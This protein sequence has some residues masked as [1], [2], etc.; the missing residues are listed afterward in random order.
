MPRTP[1]FSRLAAALL[2]AGAAA[3][4]ARAAEAPDPLELLDSTLAPPTVPYQ[5]H[6]TV[7]QWFGR[8][9]RTEEMRVFVKPPD[10]IRREFLAPDGR[11]TRVS[12]SDGDEESV[13]LVRAGKTLLG[14]AV[15]SYEKVIPPD[16]ERDTLLSN[17]E[18]S[19][20]TAERVAGRPTWRL[21]MRPRM[22]GKP[23]Q[24]LWVDQE[25]KVVLRNRR[26]IPRRS[27]A[28]RAEFDSFDP[29]KPLDDSLFEVADATSGVIEAPG[30][31]PKFLTLEQL[32]AAAGGRA[33]LPPALPGGFVFESGDVLPV[34]GR[35]VLHAR[36]TDGLIVISLFQTDRKVRIPKGGVI[37]S[38][39]VHLPGPLRASTAG[40][41]IQWGG[42]RRYYTLMG[43]VSREMIANIIKS[44]P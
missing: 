23:W 30:L 25:T 39:D 14:N 43:D 37:P 8:Q 9:T 38:G 4:A 17:Y 27:S 41:L 18:L 36:Y 34:R 40:K 2:L 21:T 35:K 12:V 13:Y 5:G 42:G 28:S 32:K 6:V 29:R 24:V 44:L 33:R 1:S 3:A 22:R 20:S 10:R 16:L 19:S 7:T 15:H 26:Y 31:A 11:V